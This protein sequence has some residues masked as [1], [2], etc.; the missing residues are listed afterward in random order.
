M[1]NVNA[2]ITDKKVMEVTTR[3]A[4]QRINGDN[5]V[6]V[7]DA[8]VLSRSGLSFGK[9]VERIECDKEFALIGLGFALAG[10]VWMAYDYFEEDIKEGIN[11]IKDKIKE[12]KK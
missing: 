8:V 6:H 11:K 2:K 4:A 12:F 9:D 3:C 1:A 5:Y 7:E 10:V